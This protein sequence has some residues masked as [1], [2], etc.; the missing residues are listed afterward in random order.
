MKV[1]KSLEDVAGLSP[2]VRNVTHSVMRGIIKAYTENGGEYVP[3]EVGYL[4]VIEG[5]ESNEEIE[6]E[7][8]YNLHEA[9]YEGGSIEQGCFVTCTL[10]NNEYGISWVIVDSPKLDSAIRAKLLRECSDGEIL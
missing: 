2:P 4:I 9:R 6:A 8:G 7:V 3:D 10:H 5:E 1:I